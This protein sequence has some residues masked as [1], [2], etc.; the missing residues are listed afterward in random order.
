MCVC[1]CVCVCVMMS[2]YFFDVIPDFIE[3]VVELG[4]LGI[5]P[6]AQLIQLSD[7]MC[8]GVRVCACV[9][10]CLCV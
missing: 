3:L 6:G 1:V 8:V 5:L 9:R 10:V 7:R 2:S 4:V